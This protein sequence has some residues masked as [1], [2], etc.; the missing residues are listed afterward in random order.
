MNCVRVLRQS[1]VVV[2]HNTDADAYTYGHTLI[3][4]N[5][6][7]HTPYEHLRETEPAHHLEIARLLS[8]FWAR[9]VGP[10]QCPPSQNDPCGGGVVRG[11]MV[12]GE[13][14]GGGRTGSKLKHVYL[15]SPSHTA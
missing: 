9:G 8:T 6:R 13:L 1:F 2:E 7:M 11:P 15:C 14:S 12:N 10:S 3:P 4:M 5:V